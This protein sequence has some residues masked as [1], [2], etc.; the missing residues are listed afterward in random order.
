MTNTHQ[1]STTKKKRILI[2]S[3]IISAGLVP[4]TYVLFVFLLPILC[5]KNQFDG[6]TLDSTMPATLLYVFIM[7]VLVILAAV[8]L[9]LAGLTS[10][11]K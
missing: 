11:K 7:T 4:I 8:L 3:G 1:L 5:E 2:T 6:C 9:V 10:R